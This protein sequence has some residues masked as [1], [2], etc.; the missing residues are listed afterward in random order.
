LI[1]IKI[2]YFKEARIKIKIVSFPASRDIKI[3]N[4]ENKKINSK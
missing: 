3:S 1:T 2:V 4:K